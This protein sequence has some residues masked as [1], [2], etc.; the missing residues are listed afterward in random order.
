MEQ[1]PLL[2]PFDRTL[3]TLDLSAFTEPRRTV[4][5]DLGCGKGR[6]LLTHAARHPDEFLIGADRLIHRLAKIDAKA[7]KM[8]IQNVRLVHAD[9]GL[10]VGCLL[11]DRSVD[12]FFV[13]FPDPWPKRRHHKRRLFSPPML[14]AFHR[15]LKPCGTIHIATDHA[16]YHKVIL[17]LFS[18]DRRFA[19]APPCEPPDEEKTDFELIFLAKG[20]RIYRCSFASLPEPASGNES[21]PATANPVS[22]A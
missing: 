22:M 14:D 19:P 8:G 18:A 15:T 7:R 1:F 16:D 6:F 21:R 13:F 10:L 5:V 2:L 9:A 17:T 20:K 4:C 3:H 12:V 11:P